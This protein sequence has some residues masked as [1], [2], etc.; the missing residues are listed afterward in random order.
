MGTENFGGR[1]GL[2]K[3]EKLHALGRDVFYGRRGRINARELWGAD[4]HLQLPEP[5]PGVHRLLAGTRDLPGP[6][7][8]RPG[9]QWSRYLPAGTCQP[10]RVG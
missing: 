5:D 2:L 10:H 6:Q 7:P 3:V 9:H 4:E 1:R 8:A